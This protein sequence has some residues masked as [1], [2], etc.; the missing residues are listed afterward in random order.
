[1]EETGMWLLQ[2]TQNSEADL[3][4]PAYILDCAL[5]SQPDRPSLS[6]SALDES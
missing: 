3:R 4:V 6:F 5:G 1:M 2:D